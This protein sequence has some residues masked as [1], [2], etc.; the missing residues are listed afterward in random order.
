MKN[1]YT[2]TFLILFLVVAWPTEMLYS[3]KQLVTE[4]LVSTADTTFRYTYAYDGLGHKVLESQFYNA[5]SDWVRYKQTELQYAGN[6]CVK[7]IER[8]FENSTWVQRY[9]IDFTYDNERLI[10]EIHTLFNGYGS[11]PFKKVTNTYVLSNLTNRKIYAW[12]V[13]DWKL[14]EESVHSYLGDG[15]LQNAIITVYNSDTISC[16]YHNDFL[17][18]NN[19]RLSDQILRQKS[20]DGL[21]LNNVESI[22]WIYSQ[23]SLSVVSQRNKKWNSDLNSW[24]NS[25]RID[26]EYDA[27]NRLLAETYQSWKLMFWDD[28]VKY[29]YEYNEAGSL[30]KT[31]VLSPIYKQWRCKRF[32]SYSNFVDLKASLLESKWDFWGGTLNEPVSTYIPFLFNEELTIKNGK[33][34]EITRGVYTGFITATG[35]QPDHSVSVYPNPSDGVFYIDT[36]QEQLLRWGVCDLNGRLM[37]QSTG[38][39]SS[40]VLDLTELE[41]GIY[42]VNV[43]TNKSSRS[44]K[45]IKH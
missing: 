7:Q 34:I 44:L 2:L 26:Y 4:M 32:I 38:N 28:A 39:T 31:Q 23:H 41:A 37:K 45:L 43:V 36:H 25:Q 20:Q 21:T 6:L 8:K 13:N 40:N 42:F 3:A 12:K 19:L 24:E 9:V 15:R 5:N 33:R 30:I 16:Q 11:A 17:Y 35:G 29:S 1:L 18:D 14:A 10:S 27:S 22:H